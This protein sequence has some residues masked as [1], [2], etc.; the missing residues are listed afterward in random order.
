MQFGA[1]KTV[2]L[3]MDIKNALNAVLPLS[4]RSKDKIEKS[5]KSD[6]TTDRDANGQMP[7][8]GGQQD[9]G[10]MSE[11][12]M[13]KALEHLRSMSAVKDHN[14]TVELTEQ[15][16]QRV[17]LVKEP[18]GKVLRRIQEAELWSLLDVSKTDKGQLLRR[19]A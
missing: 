5:I 15:N 4:L 17:V 10:P 8:G 1:E 7:Q 9:R 12:Q 3:G 14:L 18:S 2:C 16:G 6:S 11:E 19:T 13:K